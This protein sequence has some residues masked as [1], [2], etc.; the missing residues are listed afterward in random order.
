VRAEPESHCD[1]FREVWIEE[2]VGP[3]LQGCFQM[4]RYPLE[5]GSINGK[6]SV[7]GTEGLDWGGTV[8]HA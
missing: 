8:G 7:A 6:A 5:E 3:P 1:P 2:F 4:G